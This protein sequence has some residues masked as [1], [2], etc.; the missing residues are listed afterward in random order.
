[1]ANKKITVG[2]TGGIG[3]GKSVVAKVFA[4]Y[5]IPVYNS[6]ERAKQIME[7]DEAVVKF[8][9]KNFGQEV[10]EENRLNR[11]FLAKKIFSSPENIKKI[12]KIVH[13]AVIKDFKKWAAE[14]Q[15]KIVIMES[16][17]IFE[18]ALD[19]YFD[20][21]IGVFA[22]KSTRI[23]RVKSRSNLTSE[24]IENRMS[25]QFQSKKMLKKVDYTI[26]NDKKYAIIPQIESIIL[27]LLAENQK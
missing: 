4:L 24:D 7:N 3:S 1:M 13:S 16:A 20:C 14:Q 11:D 17:I 15:S 9:I 22:N 6:D 5:G 10:F 2:L 27:E 25:Q 26:F 21:I 8:L 23:K 18:S 12:N 19:K